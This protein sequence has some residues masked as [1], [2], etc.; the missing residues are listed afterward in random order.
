V[1]VR[2]RNHVFSQ[3]AAYRIFTRNLTYRKSKYP[4][5][6]DRSTPSVLAGVFFDSGLTERELRVF[7]ENWIGS[8]PERSLNDLCTCP[9]SS[10]RKLLVESLAGPSAGA[11]SSL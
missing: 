5:H 2:Q 3:V 11:R 9:R 4:F 1:D 10:V 7:R 8:N 6:G